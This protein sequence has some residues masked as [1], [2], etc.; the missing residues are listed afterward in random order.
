VYLPRGLRGVRVL[1][2]DGRKVRKSFPTL[3]AAKAWR[4]DATAALNRGRLRAPTRTTVRETA[5]AWLAGAEQGV[6]R[7]RNGHPYKPSALRG[8]RRAL[9]LRVLPALGHL[10]LS[11]LRRVDVQDFADRLLR[12]GHG[13]S[14][15]QNTLD[16]LRA[17]FRYAIRREMVVVNPC[18]GLDVPKPTGRRELV[19]SPTEAAELLDA[20]PAEDRAV[21]ATAFYAGLRRGELRGLRRSDVDLPGRELHLRRSWDA[22]EGPIAGKTRAAHRTVPLVGVL[23][24]L[25][26]GHKLLTGRDGTRSCSE[27]PPRGRSSRPRSGA[28][29]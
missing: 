24:S 20:L 25:L 15:I 10:R 7:N 16:P 1:E 18:A 5:D 27:P 14:T 3:A 13:A 19:A 29:R 8:Y 12:D 28:G 4:A 26:A 23:A 9:D 17:I 11:D 2:A 22:V 6:I 21:W